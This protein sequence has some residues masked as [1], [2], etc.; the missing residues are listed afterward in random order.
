M[1]TPKWER[2]LPLEA[3]LARIAQLEAALT[4]E[5]CRHIV[6]ELESREWSGLTHDDIRMIA[7]IINDAR[8][9]QETR[10]ES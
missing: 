10:S 7:G 5:Q 8:S 3:A 6:A 4:P 2:D 9:A 1:N